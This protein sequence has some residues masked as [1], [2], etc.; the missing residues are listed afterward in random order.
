MSKRHPSPL[1]ACSLALGLLFASSASRADPVRE[2]LPIK[3]LE[4]MQTEIETV[5]MRLA[6]MG[7][8]IL[9]VEPSTGPGKPGKI[10]LINFANPVP[11]QPECSGKPVVTL[12]NDKVEIHRMEL[13]LQAERLRN[14]DAL[15]G[16]ETDVRI[17]T[18]KE[19]RNWC[20]HRP[21]SITRCK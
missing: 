6:D 11:G 1:T 21:R 7:K 13:A 4:E 16:R 14:A 5:R 10:V 12:R 15:A 9:R 17:A 19:M 18:D 2:P 20:L 3:T 8:Q